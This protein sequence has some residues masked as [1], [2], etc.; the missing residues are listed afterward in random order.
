MAGRTIT[1][2]IALDGGQTVKTEL[3]A[4]G[5]AAQ[6]AFNRLKGA[7]TVNASLARLGTSIDGIAKRLAA[8]RIAAQGVGNSFNQFGASV[9]TSAVRFG[10][11]SAGVA[12]ALGGLAALT[13]SAGEAQ[14]A[15]QNTAD[16]LGTTVEKWQS[17]ADAAELSGIAS[18]VTEKSLMTMIAA[19]NSA[20]Q[21]TGEFGTAAKKLAQDL[22]AGRLTQTQYGAEMLKIRA[23][24]QESTNVFK[25]LG[26][27]I[28][29]SSGKLR[30]PIAVFKGLA[31]VFARM[32]NGADK[33]SYAMKLFGTENAKLV[34]FASRGTKGID[35][36]SVAAKRL[37]PALDKDARG[38]LDRARVAFTVLGKS[39][40]STSNRILSIFAPDVARVV[41]AYTEIVV[42][43][44]DAWISYATALES[45]VRPVID[46]L[47]ALLEGRDADVKNGF[48][49]K[50]RDAVLQFAADVQGA[51]RTIV[52]PA[53]MALLGVL[54]TVAQAINKIFGTEFTGGQIAIAAVVLKLLGLFGLFA[55]AVRLAANVVFLL[56]TNLRLL[57]NTAAVLVRGIVLLGTT[58]ISTFGAVPVA[59]AAIGFA[60]GYLV[61]SIVQKLGGVTG[62][63]D[64]VKTAF[65]SLAAAISGAASGIATFFGNAYT[66]LTA[67]TAA[68]V[69]GVIAWFM[70]I[71]QT[72]AIILELITA[73]VTAGWQGL[74]TL[75]Q[76]TVDSIIGIFKTGI[77]SI[78][79]FFS[80][81][82]DNVKSI[83][84]SILV[85]VSAV[86]NAVS[87]AMSSAGSG[88]AP[89]GLASGGAI[90]GPGSGTS[91]SILI[92]ASNGE[93][94][95]RAA[96]VKKY[97]LRFMDALNRGLIPV[98]RV[99][100][101]MSGI[102]FE[103]L[104]RAL[105]TGFMPQLNMRDG[106]LAMTAAPAGNGGGGRPV[107]LNLDGQSYPL[108]G[109]PDVVGALERYATGKVLRSA[110][111]KP[112]WVR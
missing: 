8:V 93:F 16:T 56:V 50:A 92:R 51:V 29:N 1:Q 42:R 84:S 94:M 54:D 15:L 25:E 106:G 72:I 62:I 49:L 103:G 88:A 43:S 112:Q 69:Q 63:I 27:S 41:E 48:I 74:V 35:Q 65:A 60:I 55:N 99:R 86:G 81:L 22:A 102:S 21:A 31:D 6:D 34:T 83:I 10:L 100:E 33:A 64:I 23:A 36:L 95:Q 7:G 30:D 78:F 17:F 19:M 32:P 80:D 90:N 111:R 46:D 47:V 4:I 38:A 52:I 66:N 85:G 76:S 73:G 87:S 18:G 45:K 14:E 109:S 70:Q 77:D 5:K 3:E 53:F 37:S 11:L 58:L 24:S 40:E 2:R 105:G 107:V 12:T 110:G 39:A 68:F 20:N 79:G 26:V 71:P 108:S 98:Q 89:S 96:A 61:V 9:R 57:Q 91:D 101:M 75:T 82:Y 13:K 28:A 104:G 97:G 44:R 67:Q 59:I